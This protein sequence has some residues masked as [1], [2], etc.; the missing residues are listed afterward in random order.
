MP[1]FRLL[2]VR[3]EVVAYNHK[4]SCE[5]STMAELERVVAAKIGV[6]F[7][8][9]IFMRDAD[10]GNEFW[11]VTDLADLAGACK[12][13]VRPQEARTCLA[14]AAGVTTREAESAGHVELLGRNAAS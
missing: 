10:F 11:R 14:G 4:L 8:V 7:P 6:D 9:W 12:I 1:S 2:V 13:E 3:N 5:A